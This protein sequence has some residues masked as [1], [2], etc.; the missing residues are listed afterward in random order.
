VCSAQQ[1]ESLFARARDGDEL[2][3]QTLWQRCARLVRSI[4]MRVVPESEADDVVQEVALAVWRGLGG[5]RGECRIETWAGKIAAQKSLD[6]LRRRK[7]VW[8]LSQALEE[9]K[10]DHSLERFLESRESGPEVDRFREQVR[11]IVGGELASLPDEQRLALWLSAAQEL[12]EKEIATLTGW[13]LGTV[14]SRVQRAKRR[15][16]GSAILGRIGRGL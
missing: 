6:W 4:A 10:A 1:D 9:C 11:D 14:R 12:T 5:F 2:A 7:R 16:K 3:F 15:L 13:P 8:L